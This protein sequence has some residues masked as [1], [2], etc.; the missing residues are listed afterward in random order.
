MQ[1]NIKNLQKPRFYAKN[2]YNRIGMRKFTVLEKADCRKIIQSLI[3]GLY[4]WKIAIMLAIFVLYK[5]QI[6]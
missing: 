1:N 5:K 6:A 2:A 4:C 3:D